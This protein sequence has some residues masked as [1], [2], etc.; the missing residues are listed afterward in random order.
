[1]RNVKANIG[2]ISNRTLSRR[3]EKCFWEGVQCDFENKLDLSEV[4]FRHIYWTLAVEGWIT[5]GGKPD[6]ICI[7]QK[8]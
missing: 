7:V 8:A 3:L 2:P 6:L 1:M 4:S 5:F